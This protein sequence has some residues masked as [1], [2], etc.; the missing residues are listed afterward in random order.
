MEVS[1]AVATSHRAARAFELV[2][3]R[4]SP[5]SA[6]PSLFGKIGAPMNQ[7]I[8]TCEHTEVRCQLS[9]PVAQEPREWRVLRKRLCQCEGQ[10]S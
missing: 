2:E 1:I 7:A 3:T 10:W 4:E 5:Y 9:P 8:D 6:R